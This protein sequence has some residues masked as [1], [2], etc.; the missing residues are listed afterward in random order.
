MHLRSRVQDNLSPN[1]GMCHPQVN[2]SASAGAR[3]TELW[4]P[5]QEDPI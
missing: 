2:G 5:A 3:H 4:T 1:Q